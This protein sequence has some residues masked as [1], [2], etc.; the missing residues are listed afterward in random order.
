M[1]SNENVGRGREE[2]GVKLGESEDGTSGAELAPLDCELTDRSEVEKIV[3]DNCPELARLLG[4]GADDK[5]VRYPAVLG[6]TGGANV[7]L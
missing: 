2:G 3:D 4:P 6:T 1:D 5:S 7:V